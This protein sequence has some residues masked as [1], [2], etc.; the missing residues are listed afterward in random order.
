[1]TLAHPSSSSKN[2]IKDNKTKYKKWFTLHVTKTDRYEIDP[3]IDVTKALSSIVYK[4]YQYKFPV[5]ASSMVQRTQNNG[6]NTCSMKPFTN[7][8][9]LTNELTWQVQRRP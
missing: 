1:M 3:I 2:F 9:A 8:T 7:S 5:P 6:E 4:F